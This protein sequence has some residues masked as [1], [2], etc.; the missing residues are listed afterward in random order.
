MDGDYTVFGKV[1]KG[2]DI[3]DA[4]VDM[5]RDSKDKPLTPVTLDVNMVSM[6]EPDLQKL[7]NGY[8]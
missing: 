6:K 5:E 1:I 8:N 4:I 7:F 3:I 2:M